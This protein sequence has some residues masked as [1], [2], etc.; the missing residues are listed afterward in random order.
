[1][2]PPENLYWDRCCP[3]HAARHTLMGT[4]CQT[5]VEGQLL[6]GGCLRGRAAPS[7]GLQK[8]G[9]HRAQGRDPRELCPQVV[10]AAGHACASVPSI[11]G[12]VE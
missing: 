10:P 4:W 11:F 8:V 9:P 6:G 5:P 3:L 7:C 2:V 12:L 1:M